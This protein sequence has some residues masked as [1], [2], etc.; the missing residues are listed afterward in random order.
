MALASAGSERC[1]SSNQAANS[2]NGS[3]ASVKSP[4]VNHLGVL[5][6]AN[7]PFRS[8]SRCL[9][10]W[11]RP[12][13]YR[14]SAFARPC[15][16]PMRLLPAWG[17]ALSLALVCAAAAAIQL[18]SMF[19]RKRDADVG[20]DHRLDPADRATPAD[21]RRHAAGGRPGRRPGGGQR[22]ARQG[23]HGRQRAVGE[24]HDRRARHRHAARRTPTARTAPPAA[25]SW[26]ATCA[27][28]PESWLQ[29]EA[30]RGSRAAGRSARCGPGGGP[31][32]GDAVTT[33]RGAALLPTLC[34]DGRLGPIRVMKRPGGLNDAR[35]L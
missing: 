19:S 13:R 7:R 29:G 33:L 35:P 2:R 1:A 9:C 27:T 4:A 11:L 23:R 10:S 3:S 8:T 26:R 18:D 5:S 31:E 17:A 28:A 12:S 24:S 21:R 22:G 16:R 14:G 25:T 20:D 30:C 34:D 15:R 6:A 32:A